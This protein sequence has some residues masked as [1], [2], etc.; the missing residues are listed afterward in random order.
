M[1]KRILAAVAACIALSACDT[2]NSEEKGRK[3]SEEF[4][5]CMEDNSKSECEDE[6]NDNYGSYAGDDEFVDAFNS[7]NDCG[8]TI[9][10]VTYSVATRAFAV[11]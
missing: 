11:H 9:K 5:E 1:K 8:I 3:A 6:L 2:L 10:T 7:A 4:C